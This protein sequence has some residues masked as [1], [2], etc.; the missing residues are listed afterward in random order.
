M[1]LKLMIYLQ[2]Q[3]SVARKGVISWSAQLKTTTNNKTTPARQF[4]EDKDVIVLSFQYPSSWLAEM[5][6][7]Y[8]FTNAAF[9]FKLIYLKKRINYFVSY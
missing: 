5:E 2:P 6:Y 3:R 4:Q 1:D 8:S 9:H 7:A